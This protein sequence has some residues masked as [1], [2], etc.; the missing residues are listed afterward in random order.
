MFVLFHR[1]L[2][3]SHLPSEARKEGP[4]ERN[5]VLRGQGRSTYPTQS[6]PSSG[7]D[8]KTAKENPKT[9]ADASQASSQH[10]EDV[11]ESENETSTMVVKEKPNNN[12]QLCKGGGNILI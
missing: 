11:E 8:V 7:T 3:S 5:I 2:E 6:T 10:K 4:P 12:R 9:V 1:R